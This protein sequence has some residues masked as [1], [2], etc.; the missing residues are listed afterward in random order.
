MHNIYILHTKRLQ[1]EPITKPPNATHQITTFPRKTLTICPHPT[2][3]QFPVLFAYRIANCGPRTHFRGSFPGFPGH[4]RKT[5][6]APG[7]AR[8]RWVTAT[9]C[10]RAYSF[11]LGFPGKGALKGW[12]GRGWGWVVR[13]S[14]FVCP[15]P[16]LYYSIVA[17]TSAR[18]RR[19][20]FSGSGSLVHFF[21]FGERFGN[22]FEFGS[23]RVLFWWCAF[24]KCIKWVLLYGDELSLWIYH[25]TNQKVKDISVKYLTILCTCFIW[26]RK[27]YAFVLYKIR[28]N[29]ST[30]CLQ[31][32]KCHKI[33]HIHA[34][35]V[36]RFEN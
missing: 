36:C 20:V 11:S 18:V 14:L 1:L 5:Q 26:Y 21:F 7:W 31:T 4:D 17:F 2:P 23:G 9:C 3:T 35:R 6:P 27:Q 29:H 30:V 16:K 25:P 24:I 13:N 10:E 12:L 22:G 19:C 33:I 34:C 8:G 15:R 32:N 28:Y